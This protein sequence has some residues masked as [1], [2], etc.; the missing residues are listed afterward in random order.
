MAPPCTVPKA[1]ST[2]MP[3]HFSTICEKTTS[4]RYQRKTPANTAPTGDRRGPP[5]TAMTKD[6]MNAPA[7]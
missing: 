4:S 2:A 1:T 7:A 6:P 3:A 5:P